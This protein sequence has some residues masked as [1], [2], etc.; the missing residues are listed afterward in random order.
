[1]W[2]STGRHPKRTFGGVLALLTATATLLQIQGAGIG[3]YLLAPAAV[4]TLLISGRALVHRGGKPTT[5]VAWTVLTIVASGY[6]VAVVAT[7]GDS[8]A[9]QADHGVVFS[10]QDYFA[11]L[12]KG[13]VFMACT[14]VIATPGSPS[15]AA[16]KT[17]AAPSTNS[18]T[19][20]RP[21][22][23]QARPA[24]GA[25]PG[26][27]ASGAGPASPGSTARAAVGAAVRRTK[28]TTVVDPPLGDHEPV[29]GDAGAAVASVPSTPAVD[30]TVVVNGDD[31]PPGGSKTPATSAPSRGP[32]SNAAA[33]ASTVPPDPAV[34][35][36]AP[37]APPAPV[38]PPPAP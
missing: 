34:A 30:P 38:V 7:L 37:A 28:D 32:V 24:V 9:G 27:G 16:P 15:A 19:D 12:A 18:P 5:A 3:V 2:E 20:Q 14:P 35:G 4:C 1:M 26:A 31:A 29:S 8:R 6:L 11:A 33:P 22:P 23:P 21:A 13:T 10:I 36:G 17:D 25:R